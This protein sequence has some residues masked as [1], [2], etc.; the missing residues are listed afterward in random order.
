MLSKV[1]SAIIS[2]VVD[3]VEHIYSLNLEDVELDY[4]DLEDV[5]RQRKRI[6]LARIKVN[7]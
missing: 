4:V 3:I 2:P 1:T 7:E 6:D 5:K